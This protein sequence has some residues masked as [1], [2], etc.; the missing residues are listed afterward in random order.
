M[1]LQ[2][3]AAADRLLL[4]LLLTD[5]ALLLPLLGGGYQSSLEL[6]QPYELAERFLQLQQLWITGLLL[7][8]ALR[9]LSYLYLGWAALFGFLLLDSAFHFNAELGALLVTEGSG[10]WLGLEPVRAGQLEATTVTGAL[11][12]LVLW[13]AHACAQSEHKPLSRSLF[14]AAVALGACVVVLDTLHATLAHTSTGA[15]LGA[16]AATGEML[17]VS[18]ALWLVLRTR[19]PV[20]EMHD[21]EQPPAEHS[22]PG[23]NPV[24]HPPLR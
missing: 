3:E 21:A 11:F 9:R 8:L 2:L 20:P 15:S 22:L 16:L 12:L 1:R 23:R 7:E 24:A 17:A 19:L 4:L 5:I 18:G 13:V 10:G 14:V 6:G